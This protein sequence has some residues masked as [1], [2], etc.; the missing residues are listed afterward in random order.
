MT[1]KET[2]IR[3]VND[4]GLRVHNDGIELIQQGVEDELGIDALGLVIGQATGK[5]GYSFKRVAERIYTVLEN[6]HNQQLNQDS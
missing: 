4:V 3:V 6:Q 2:I 1:I 5:P